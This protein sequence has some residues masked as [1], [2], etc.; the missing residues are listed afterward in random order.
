MKKVFLMLA[1]AGL[2][3]SVSATVNQDDKT[4]AKKEC[5]KGDKACCKDKKGAEGKSCAGDAKGEKKACCKDKKS[6][7][8]AV[9]EPKNEET[10]PATVK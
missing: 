5:K 3:G 8:S 6:G 4:A 2:V 9:V 7:S 1:F 10:K